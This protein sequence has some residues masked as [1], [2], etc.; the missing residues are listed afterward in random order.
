LTPFGRG[1]LA[2]RCS[3]RLP[4]PEG[5]LAD[6]YTSILG[7]QVRVKIAIDISVRWSVD[8]WARVLGGCIRAA[9]SSTVNLKEILMYNLN[10]MVLLGAAL[11]PVPGGW[12]STDT[13]M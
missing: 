12:R 10:A 13:E 7:V 8:L 1:C 5:R 3:G 4:F 11:L 6:E 2:G 9:V